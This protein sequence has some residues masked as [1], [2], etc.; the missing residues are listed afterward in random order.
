MRV[1]A[2]AVL[3]A[4]LLSAAV[5]ACAPAAALA[6]T[7]QVAMFEADPQLYAHPANTLAELR[8]LGVDVV[9]V[10]VH[11]GGPLG[12]APAVKPAGFPAAAP[13]AAYNWAPLDAI[14]KDARAQGI[15]VDLTL[16]GPPPAWAAGRGQPHGGGYPEWRPSA[17]AYGDFVRAVSARYTGGFRPSP[18]AAPLPAV[19]WWELWN[20]PN[21]GQ[22]LAP[23]AVR[24]STVPSAPSLYRALLAAGWSALGDTGHG[25]DR[26][27][28]GNLDAR[29]QAGGPGPQAPEGYPGYF[30]D[31]KPL[32]FVRELYCVDSR[33][34][35]V[36]GRV[37]SAQGCPATAAASRRFRAANP[38]LFAASGFADHPYPYHGP[39]TVADSRDPNYAEF[40][41]LPKL[42]D[43]LAR[44]ARAYGSSH[45]F[46]IYN[47]EYGYITNPP[48]SKQ[49]FV[50]P[51]RAAVYLNW[52][53]YL[54]WRNPHIASTMQYLLVDPPQGPSGFDSGL[55]FYGG[56]H[57]PTYDAYRLPLFLPRS[58][59]RRGHPVTVWGCARPA[60]TFHNPRVL[61][62]F[63]ARNHGVWRTVRTVVVTNS[64]GYFQT[65]LR[66]PA[67][68]A[69]RLAWSYPHG[70]TI[71]SR[72]ATV[73]VR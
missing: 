38:A 65:T 7:T 48:N 5:L 54:S 3:T 4:L 16:S 13:W 37:A 46:A 26:I 23:Q 63:R 43:V 61:I 44:S 50:S 70:A 11:W 71:H 47:N 31:T 56:R 51:A 9:R 66:L 32:T 55:E 17:A 72:T 22:E 27:L 57:K 62:Q 20:E 19:H 28:I 59:V 10:A 29:G 53:E 14:V 6:S 58:R 49:P 33:Y 18:D 60:P 45:R 73:S 64:R 68:G 69:V 40:S 8:S 30:G 12:L 15:V 24:G 41:E 1:T 35:P 2:R 42:Y 25:R 36:R 52:A 67:S 39:P 21:F 34:R